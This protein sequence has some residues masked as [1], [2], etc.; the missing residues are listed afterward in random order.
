MDSA[1]RWAARGDSLMAGISLMDSLMACTPA[2]LTGSELTHRV[3]FVI[4]WV[5]INLFLAER[6]AVIA[7]G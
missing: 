1:G 6:A 5:E 4:M 7:E 2:S 3:D